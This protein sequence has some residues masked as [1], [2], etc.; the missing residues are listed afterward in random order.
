MLGLFLIQSVFTFLLPVP[1]VADEI[2]QNDQQ[3]GLPTVII[4]LQETSQTAHVGPSDSGEVVFNGT[5]SVSSNPATQVEVTLMAEDTWGTSTVIPST[6]TFPRSGI[7]S[8]TVHVLAP[9][10]ESMSNPGTVTVTGRWELVPGGLGGPADPVSG[11]TGRIEIGQFYAFSITSPQTHLQGSPDSQMVFSITIQNNGNGLD[12]FSI[13]IVNERELIDKDFDII[14]TQKEIEIL[15]SPAEDNVRI[16]VSVPPSSKSLGQTTIQVEVKSDHGVGE[17][18][19]AQNIDLV[20][21]VSGE[22]FVLTTEFS[23]ILVIILGLIILGIFLFW[24]RRRRRRKKKL[25]KE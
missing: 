25:M 14:M 24:R 7:E 22:N 2:P 10:Q 23:Y 8:F 4:S 5:V 11:V 19:P 21:E 20:V 12:L 3:P 17:G 6:L 9:A 1:V 13:E 16:Q 18:V 15:E